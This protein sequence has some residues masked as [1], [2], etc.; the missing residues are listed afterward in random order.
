MNNSPLEKI[1]TTIY[2]TAMDIEINADWIGV[3]YLY[4]TPADTKRN[5]YAS[6]KK[7]REAYKQLK[8]MTGLDPCKR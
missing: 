6:A 4:T 7:L 3:P 5:F 8:D 1:M 2:D